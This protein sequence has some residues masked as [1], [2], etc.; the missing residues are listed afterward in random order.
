M[1]RRYRRGS[2]PRLHEWGSIVFFF[3]PV[4]SIILAVVVL[5]EQLTLR[6]PIRAALII[7][8]PLL[9]ICGR[10]RLSAAAERSAT[11]A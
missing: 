6:F 9:T 1:K 4:I 3:K 11:E 5:H 8:G 2:E 7:A 10:G